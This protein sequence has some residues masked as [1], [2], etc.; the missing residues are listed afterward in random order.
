MRKVPDM[1]ANP[2]F[3]TIQLNPMEF[4]ITDATFDNAA[5]NYGDGDGFSW[6]A[7]GGKE[8]YKF[9]RMDRGFASDDGTPCS[10]WL[11]EVMNPQSDDLLESYVVDCP[12]LAVRNHEGEPARFELVNKTMNIVLDLFAE[13]AELRTQHP[14]RVSCTGELEPNYHFPMPEVE[15]AEEEEPIWVGAIVGFIGALEVGIIQARPEQIFATM[16]QILKELMD[17]GMLTDLSEVQR[18]LEDHDSYMQMFAMPARDGVPLGCE[19]VD[20]LTG[21]TRDHWL[22]FSYGRAEIVRYRAEN[23]IDSE[24]NLRMLRDRTGIMIIRSSDN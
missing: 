11:V 8:I 13:E 14:F 1:V 7:G 2:E 9:R 16:G 15:A 19:V 12:G 10:V 3:S 24:H 22:S 18:Y 4:G 5:S 23:G 17:A 6:L 20:M 21:E